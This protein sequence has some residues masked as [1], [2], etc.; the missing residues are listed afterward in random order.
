[1]TSPSWY[2]CRARKNLP[3]NWGFQAS[4]RVNG[5]H[6]CGGS[7]VDYRHVL[8]AAHCCFDNTGNPF[9]TRSMSIAAGN[10]NINTPDVSNLRAVNT[11]TV[12]R[13]YDPDKNFDD[14]AVLQI[15]GSF[16]TWSGTM[17][18]ID[19][20]N[21]VPRV[22]LLCTVCG[23]GITKFNTTVISSNLLYV[24]IPIIGERQC[25][26]YYGSYLTNKM[27]CAGGRG[28]DSCQVRQN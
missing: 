5:K 1:M 9:P 17:K 14:I 23:W 18:P 20:A 25:R 19:L 3:N 27:I 26:A 22:G 28:K 6:I 24:D 7:I 15:F 12:H 2:R 16:K 10:L 21:F 11:V 8:T 4:L 13:N